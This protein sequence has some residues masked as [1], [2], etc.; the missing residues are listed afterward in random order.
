[1][2]DWEWSRRG[3]L[4]EPRRELRG[5]AVWGEVG[6]FGIPRKLKLLGS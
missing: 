4:G 6:E 2:Q 1:M 5:V 3:R